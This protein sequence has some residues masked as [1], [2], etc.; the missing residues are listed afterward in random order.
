MADHR[1]VLAAA[2]ARRRKQLRLPVDLSSTGG[3]S[4]MTVRKVESAAPGDIRPATRTRL[5]KALLWRPGIV[6]SV[7]AGTAPSDPEAWV[8][9]ESAPAQPLV[10]DLPELSVEAAVRT[11]VADL[12]EEAPA[13]VS[14]VALALT[15]ARKLDEGAGLATAAV[16]R[17]LRSTL[18]VLTRTEGDDDDELADFVSR[19]SAPM[20]DPAIS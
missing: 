10:V 8:A 7:L 13:H 5:E 12:P 19:L 1:S 11:T 15:L 9:S 17:E 6:A 16:A 2:V 20:G 18:D 4:E 14:L 3:P